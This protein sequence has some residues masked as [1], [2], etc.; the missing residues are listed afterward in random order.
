[1]LAREGSVIGR[2]KKKTQTCDYWLA[3]TP[4]DSSSLQPRDVTEDG[5]ERSRARQER[6][7]L[8]WRGSGPGPEPRF[9]PREPQQQGSPAGDGAGRAGWDKPYRRQ[10]E[11]GQAQLGERE[12]SRDLR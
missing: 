7:Q 10:L 2:K 11:E 1:M 9:W 5:D 8:A 6:G 12:A 3:I 4:L